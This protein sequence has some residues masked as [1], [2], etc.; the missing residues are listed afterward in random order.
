MIHNIIDRRQRQHRWKTVNAVI[1][2]TSQDNCVQNADQMADDQGVGSIIYDERI[3]I[4]LHDAVTWAQGVD[5]N[6]TLYLY[7]QGEGI[8]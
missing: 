7:D 6:V 1:E 5:A 2:N 3:G 4:S 8:G